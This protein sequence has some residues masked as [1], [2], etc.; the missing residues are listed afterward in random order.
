MLLYA[1]QY[2]PSRGDIL[3]KRG[4]LGRHQS[5]TRRT[6]TASPAPKMARVPIAFPDISGLSNVYWWLSI[7]F[8]V[9]GVN[10]GGQ[11][12][13]GITLNIRF[14]LFRGSGKNS[15]FI[16][17]W[18]TIQLVCLHQ[19]YAPSVRDGFT[20]VGSRGL[21][22]FYSLVHLT[23]LPPVRKGRISIGPT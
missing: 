18:G 16:H 14:F 23:A 6:E 10:E 7:N 21:D 12:A 1:K 17:T 2:N 20:K 9:Y 3:V 11:S 13:K 19:R 5:P 4:P 8:G 22:G 15:H